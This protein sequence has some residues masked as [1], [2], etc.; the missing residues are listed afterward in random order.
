V[1]SS[2]SISGSLPGIDALEAY[3][4]VGDRL[5]VLWAA[6]LH[7][8]QLLGAALLNRDRDDLQTAGPV[9]AQEV[10]GVGDTYRLLAEVFDRLERAGQAKRV[11]ERSHRFIRSNFEPGR[12][13]AN[14]LDFQDQ[15]GVWCDRAN[16]RVHRTFRAVPAEW[17]LEERVRMR[18]L[19]E[20]PARG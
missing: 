7:L 15:L 2:A 9:R 16:Q 18:P 4:A 19:P 3:L 17:L 11:L 20:L 5:L 10:G 12:R 6:D 1:A 13:L 8:P 14:E